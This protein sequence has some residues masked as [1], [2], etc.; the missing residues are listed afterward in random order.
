MLK[1]CRSILVGNVAEIAL[2]IIR[3]TIKGIMVVKDHL[4][5][6]LL[7]AP[8]ELSPRSLGGIKMCLGMVI[9]HWK[10]SKL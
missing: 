6:N 4:H 3:A 10:K 8:L 7:Q 5:Q 1:S 9:I 2:Y